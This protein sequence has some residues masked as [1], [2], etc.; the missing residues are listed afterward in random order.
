MLSGF[1]VTLQAQTVYDGELPEGYSVCVET[2]QVHEEG[3]DGAVEDLYGY[4]TYRVYINCANTTD[5]VQTIF[6]ITGQVT[7]VTFTDSLYQEANFGA[8][9]S[10]SDLNCFLFGTPEDAADLGCPTCY[11]DSYVTIGAHCGGATDPDTG[12]PWTNTTAIASAVEDPD[13]LTLFE[14][15]ESFSIDDEV[16]GGWY[17]IADAESAYNTWAGDDLKIM[18]GQFTTKGTVS[19]I[20]SFVIQPEGLG[21][22]DAWECNNIPF[23]CGSSSG[24]TDPT[25]CNYDADAVLDD[26]S[27]LYPCALEFAE[28]TTIN[29]ICPD[30]PNGNIT[31]DVDGGQAGLT[32]EVEG[33]GTSTTGIFSNMFTAGTYTVMAYDNS[34]VEC[35][36]EDD[37]CIIT[38]EVTFDMEPLDLEIDVTNP[39]CYNQETGVINAVASGGTAPYS[40][41]LEGG[42]PQLN[43]LWENLEN[44]PDYDVVITDSLGCIYEE[45]VALNNPPQ[46]EIS[47][48]IVTNSECGNDPN[49]TAEVIATGGTGS[50]GYALMGDD[51]EPDN[52][53]TDLGGGNFTAVVTDSVGCTVNED[54]TILAP[55]PISIE[56]VSS[57]DPV[58][59]ET[60][61]NYLLDSLGTIVLTDP[62]GGSGTLNVNWTSVPAGYVPTPSATSVELINCITGDYTVTITDALGCSTTLDVTL[63]QITSTHPD[64]VTTPTTVE[65]LDGEL[66]FSLYPNPSN[67]IFNINFEGLSGNRVTYQIVDALGRQI[68]SKDLSNRTGSFSEEI[69]ISNEA[70]G[71]YYLQVVSGDDF[72]TVKIVK[73]D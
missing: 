8:G 54:F 71:F 68:V 60:A 37:Q 46:I 49:G 69:N 29:P 3:V 73:Q 59:C 39:L 67:G 17:S 55:D 52:V 23:P 62:T 1:V 10:S 53:I 22:T 36:N 72:R 58:W 35:G 64:C 12:L 13:W 47:S 56:F 28:I 21:G 44:N 27:C 4:T 42:I 48:I 45:S 5:R 40:Y 26:N 30:S 25:A 20:L 34:P 63:G 31:I 57:T 18:A 16:G 15:G 32:Y 19:G 61:G 14:G 24:C 50:L 70:N 65:E 2:L 6:G 33:Y 7:A 9:E 38:Q 41:V 66:S 43:G 11:Y 51:P